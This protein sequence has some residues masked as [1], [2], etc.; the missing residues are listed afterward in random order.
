[1]SG[2][3]DIATNGVPAANRRCAVAG[4]SPASSTGG[5]PIIG[6]YE[7]RKNSVNSPVGYITPFGIPVVP[8][9]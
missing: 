9:V 1:M 6:G 8:P 3:P 2:G 4:S 7:R 5:S